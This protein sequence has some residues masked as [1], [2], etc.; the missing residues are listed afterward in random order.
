MHVVNIDVYNI[1]NNFETWL[2]F[3]WQ[4]IRSQVSKF[5]W[6]YVKVAPKSLEF[7]TTIQFSSHVKSFDGHFFF[8]VR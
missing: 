2:L 6:I 3:S 1:F 4:P 7:F 8:H 5:L